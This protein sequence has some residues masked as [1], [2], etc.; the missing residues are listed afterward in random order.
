M[1]NNP[2][3]SIVLNAH[4]PFIRH[5]EQ[6]DC[7]QERLFFEAVSDTYIP[8]LEMFDRLDRDHV[9]FRMGISLSS[10]LCHMLSDS[11]LLKRYLAFTDKQIEFGAHELQ[12]PYNALSPAVKHFYNRMVD[13][14]VLFTERYEG[15]L[16]KVFENYQKKGRLEL[17]L[18][19][20]THAFLPFYTA[21]PEAI[22][23]E[24]EVAIGAYRSQFG[25]NPQGFW[26]PEMGWAPELDS[27]LRS[28]NFA[29]TMVDTH[30]LVFGHPCAEKGSFYP[31]KT[32]AGVFIL[33]RDF[34]AKEDID[35][36]SSCSEYRD[37][38]KDLGFE[39]PS[40]LLKPF[41]GT[42][43]GRGS[44]GYKC[45]TR[46]GAVY[47][48]G[49]AEQKARDQARIF[50]KNRQT[51]LG[52]ARTLMGKPPLC[53]CAF[54]ADDFGCRWYEGPRFLE[55]IFREGTQDFQFMT[56]AEYL[57]KQEPSSFQTLIPE[58]SSWGINGFGETW[59]DASN[60]WIYRHTTRALERMI[61]IS[62]RFPDNSGLKERTLNQA[63]REILLS[64]ASDWPGM[65]YR[66]ENSVYARTQVESCLRNFTTIYEALGSNYIS[67]EWLTGLEKRH[68][69]FPN[70][71]YRVF[72][73]KT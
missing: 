15:N 52:E 31:A 29:Y 34:Y 11:H 49:E 42:Q 65:L 26:L 68:N 43:R 62:D 3:I 48:F 13:K 60:D 33:G 30:G 63:A 55:T 71:N 54:D 17:L 12:P 46:G 44:T 70:I 56:P 6:A 50:L 58:F 36:L 25:K 72:R 47:D 14:R 27:W 53:L 64:M 16:L 40:N 38:R 23:A 8:L 4:I 19:A 51:R 9:P 1:N 5:P 73:R 45:R 24:I 7:L 69:I 41:L 57:Y 10:T 67:T 28:Y 18:T 37:N 66:Q 59:T 22:Q 21:Y 61:E 39:L 35:A 20:A 2:V 32:P